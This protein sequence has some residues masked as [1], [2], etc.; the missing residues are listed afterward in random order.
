MNV[1]KIQMFNKVIKT[2]KINMTTM[3]F[4]KK[5]KMNIVIIMIT[6]KKVKK[7]IEL[8][9]I[10]V[11]FKEVIVLIIVSITMYYIVN[12]RFRRIPFIQFVEPIYLLFGSMVL[13]LIRIDYVYVHN[14]NRIENILMDLS[15]INRI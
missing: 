3:L 5:V 6:K 11:K 2:I 15:V 14:H 9:I 13:F 7:M 4:T 12:G 10:I 1:Q 8:E